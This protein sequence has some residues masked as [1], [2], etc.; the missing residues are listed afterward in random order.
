MKFRLLV[1]LAASAWLTAPI[2]AQDITNSTQ[3]VQQPHDGSL[4]TAPASENTTPAC[5]RFENKDRP[6]NTAIQAR[7]TEL[8]DSSHLKPGDQ[9][10]AKVLYDIT[11]PGCSLPAEA[12]LYG[13]VTA[14]AS[15]KN[16]K[17]SEL[18]LV[19]DHADCDD[20]QKQDLRMRLIGLVAPP[21][22]TVM[23]HDVLPSEVAGGVQQLPVTSNS[24]IDD[25][26]NPEKYP[27]TVHPGLVVRMPN[28]KLEPEGGPGC[29]TRI[30]S[31]GRNIQLA[32]GDELILTPEK[33]IK[34]TA[35]A[36]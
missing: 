17:S 14:A 20:G 32:P 16:P 4:A 10:F 19:F 13:H 7:V 35:S 1:W 23:L 24:G 34:T 18:G 11:Y 28:V 22:H 6:V 36:H 26:L 15:S 21:D 31:S 8:M 2:A 3:A 9:V 25:N 29:S 5:P 30:S 12:I 27:L 33:V